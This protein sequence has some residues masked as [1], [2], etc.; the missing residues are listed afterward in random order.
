MQKIA[1]FMEEI[2]YEKINEEMSYL[3]EFRERHKRLFQLGGDILD[4]TL[5]SDR[6]KNVLYYFG[7]LKRTEA[8]VDLYRQLYPEKELPRETEGL[9]EIVEYFEE[10]LTG[11]LSL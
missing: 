1:L 3:K 11:L 5:D 4:D 8:L 7:C 9:G 2:I 6:Y 10:S